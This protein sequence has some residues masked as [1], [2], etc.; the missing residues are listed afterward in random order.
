MVS[1]RR[2]EE[3]I[4]GAIL[5]LSGVIGLLVK[6]NLL[7]IRLNMQLSGDWVRWWPLAFVAAG[8]AWLAA[9]QRAA[10]QGWCKTLHVSRRLR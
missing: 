6:L 5:L 8:V 4:F 9:C 2:P 1:T 3:V 10:R 7:V